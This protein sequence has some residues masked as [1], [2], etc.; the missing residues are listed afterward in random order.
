MNVS[1]PTKLQLVKTV[2]LT[3]ITYG[4]GFFGSLVAQPVPVTKVELA[5]ASAAG[6][7]AAYR[8]IKSFLTDL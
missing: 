4:F 3:V 7:A 8:V 5:A 6:V 1:K 2:E